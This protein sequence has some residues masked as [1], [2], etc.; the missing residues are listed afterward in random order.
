MPA[1]HG[2]SVSEERRRGTC[3]KNARKFIL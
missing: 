3:G 1:A 2:R